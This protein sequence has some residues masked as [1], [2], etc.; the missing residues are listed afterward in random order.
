MNISKEN[1]SELDLQIKIDV[2]ENDY[3]ERVTKQLKR[4]QKQATL[5]GFRKGM[6]P[7][8][9]IE[10]NYKANVV[11]DEVQNLLG[12]ELYKYID[13]QK[14]NIIGTPLANDEKTG[15]VDFRNGKA[16]T[17][18][19][20]CA[21]APEVNIDWNAIDVKRMQVKV[22]AKDTEKQI[23]DI[24]NRFGKFETPETIEATD[25]VYGKVVELDKEGKAKEDGLSSFTSFAL[26][27]LKDDDM[28]A[29]FVGKKNED[30]VVFNAAKAFTA[31]NI[32]HNFHIDEAAAKKFKADVELTISGISRITPAEVNEELFAKVFPGQEVKDEA[33]FKKLLT[34]EIEKANNEQCDLIYVSEVRKALVDQFNAPMPEA[35]L[36]RWILSRSEDMTAEQI[37]AEWAEKYVPS[38]KWEFIDGALNKIKVL[39]P[40][41][42]DVIN[43]IKDILG[44][45]DQQIEGETEE[46]KAKRLD[47]AART[48]ASDRRNV[49]QIV[50]KLYSDNM[51]ALL[52]EQLKSEVEKVTLKELAERMK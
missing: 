22:S 6:A 38:L 26:A 13:D 31:T 7:Y 14:L 8:A 43:Y 48:I 29:L 37:E 5:P 33:A 20:D 23:E 19:F 12:E 32:A 41:Q 1:I 27:D 40:K 15:E 45:N 24:C 28:R 3:A 30:K 34:K 39:E 2:A 47:E 21:L 18:Y 17:F 46:D 25:S 36:K 44:K 50:D 4:Y 16:F 10:R 42:E 51:I 11:A 49:Q 9:L 35:F 52:E